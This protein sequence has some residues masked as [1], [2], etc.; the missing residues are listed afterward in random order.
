[1]EAYLD[2]VIAWLSNDLHLALVAMVVMVLLICVYDYWNR[3]REKGMS[4][5]QRK[6][7]RKAVN[8]DIAD[9]VSLALE[10]AVEKQQLERED[11]NGFYRNMAKHGY[12]DLGYE[13]SFGKPWYKKLPIPNVA[14]VKGAIIQRLG[15]IERTAYLKGEMEK[16]KTRKKARLDRLVIKQ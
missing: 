1:M 4:R 14:K 12:R 5:A 8:E 2:E 10:D 13:P 15:G 11:V 7:R 9:R 16:V 3:H 6:A